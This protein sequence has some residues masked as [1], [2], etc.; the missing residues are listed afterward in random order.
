VSSPA[1]KLRSGGPG[2]SLARAIP[3]EVT[4]PALTTEAVLAFLLAAALAGVAFGAKGGLTLERTTA[5]EI[6][7]VLG[8]A[9]VAAVA[10]LIAPTPRRAW[11]AVSLAAVAAL[12]ALTA[13]SVIWSVQP[14]DTWLQAN[15]LLAY[16][17]AF[18]AAIGLARVTPRGSGW[19]VAAV[20]MACLAVCG[21]ALL[22]K[23]LPDS[24]NRAD[25]YGRLREPFGYW[26]AV[27]LMA[28]L[29]V[30]ALLWLGTRREGGPRVRAL[31]APVLA[32][33]L[34]TM[35]L[36]TSRASLLAAAVGAA[37][38]F[39]LVPRRIRG[40]AVLGLAGLGAAVVMA[41]GF[42]QDGLTKDGVRL[43]TRADAGHLLGIFL[44]VMIAALFAASLLLDRRAARRPL[45]PGLRRHL[46]IA[47]IVAVALLPVA[48]VGLLAAS[49]RG[50]EGSITHAWN[51]VTDPSAA[52]GNSP[53]RLTQ[54]GS[55][56]G[57]YWDEAWQ[58]FQQAPVV[59]SG[60]GTFSTARTHFRTDTV[61]A[62]HAHGYAVQDL[63]ELGLA[64]AA[65]SLFALV[66]WGLAAARA[67][68]ARPR[69]PAALARAI[70]RHPPPATAAAPGFRDL[71]F[72]PERIAVLT[73]IAGVLVFGVHSL[74]D[75]TWF[76][77]G[78]AV[79]ALVGA[80]Y[81]AGRGP[82]IAP[83]G[84]RV[85]GTRW[86]MRLAIA[87]ALVAGALLAAW[88]IWQ[89]L[90]SDQAANAALS[91]LSR[92]DVAAAYVNVT[93]ARHRNPLAAEPLFDQA[94]I[95][96]S[97]GRRRAAERLLQ[98]AVRLQPGNALTW[99]RL[100]QY[101]LNA[102]QR[103]RAAVDELRAA[104]FLDP[105]SPA[106]QR[107]FVAATRALATAEQNRRGRQSAPATPSTP[108]PVPGATAPTPAPV[109]PRAKTPTPS[110]GGTQ[111]N[112]A[113]SK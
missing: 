81:V 37:F 35:L 73:L 9:L 26:N 47:L 79:V 55:V 45:S 101:E 33:M 60:A 82:F 77:P 20:L 3:R 27:G 50:L 28:A 17:V 46:G 59:G 32:L 44:V 63:A 15:L 14:S 31:A 22:T 58:V 91:A 95:E 108:G 96:D 11:G 16:L 76:V 40:A 8:G 25:V 84:G 53:S 61:A 52:A 109:R 102:M 24:L 6:A 34:V 64:G 29:A 54:A 99:H 74:V 111:P 110:T 68:G 98:Q 103:P 97:V 42:Q 49:K 80:G 2:R 5:T 106:I 75:W 69:V 23:V 10:A 112:T 51:Q 21:W 57:K 86:S 94:T 18:G 36:S 38:W 72:T 87:G 1:V 12:A 41:W 92:N 67:G 78:T 90:R 104:L 107:D 62:H 105:R 4:V 43:A 7:L 70:R 89:P 39:A 13:A 19:V 93:K 48:G 66:A 88:T 65:A 71:P 113:P 30:P 83:R 100:G 56:R 85:P